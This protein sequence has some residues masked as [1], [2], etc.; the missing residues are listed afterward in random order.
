MLIL[1]LWGFN[2]CSQQNNRKETSQWLARWL[3]KRNA[4]EKINRRDKA[5]YMALQNCMGKMQSYILY[6]YKTF[7]AATHRNVLRANNLWENGPLHTISCLCVDVISFVFPY[8][9]LYWLY[10]ILAR[11]LR[12]ER[13]IDRSRCFLFWWVFSKPTVYVEL[14]KRC[15]KY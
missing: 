11:E 4:N 10:C 12:K 8:C 15:H 1:K 14:L 7:C 13:L 5:S 2:K 9:I 6:S 3:G